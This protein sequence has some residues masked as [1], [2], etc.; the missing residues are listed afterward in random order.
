VPNTVKV[1]RAVKLADSVN[2]TRTTARYPAS[3][4][5]PSVIDTVIT[6]SLHITTPAEFAAG[7]SLRHGYSRGT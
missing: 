6:A 4:A 1:S 2:R 5:L 7:S 3:A